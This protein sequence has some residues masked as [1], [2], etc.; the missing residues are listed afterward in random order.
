MIKKTRIIDL[1]SRN[2]ANDV[3]VEFAERYRHYAR[4]ANHQLAIPN[5]GM[6]LLPEVEKIEIRDPLE[7]GYVGFSNERICILCDTDDKS[8]DKLIA[9]ENYFNF[10]IDWMFRIPEGEKIEISV[11]FTSI[12]YV[13]DK[14]SIPSAKSKKIAAALK[15]Q[16]QMRNRMDIKYTAIGDWSAPISIEKDYNSKKVYVDTCLHDNWYDGS[17]RTIVHVVNPMSDILYSMKLHGLVEDCDAIWISPSILSMKSY[18]E[19]EDSFIGHF[20]IKEYKDIDFLINHQLVGVKK[21][22]ETTDFANMNPKHIAC[23]ATSVH[24]FM[25]FNQAIVMYASNT[26]STSEPLRLSLFINYTPDSADDQK[27]YDVM[28][29][30]MNYIEN[31]AP[32][33]DVSFF[34]L[35]FDVSDGQGWVDRDKLKFIPDNI[36]LYHSKIIDALCC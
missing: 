23:F 1:T 13:F 3:K 4:F 30:F 18:V 19:I 28:N 26:M 20:I 29:S 31:N 5:P 15:W 11:V 10:W 2:I 6:N 32:I 27:L 9:V 33:M 22:D 35:P 8:M 12:P 24:D 34:L 14:D 16:V 25:T 7:I 21:D 17:E 36:E